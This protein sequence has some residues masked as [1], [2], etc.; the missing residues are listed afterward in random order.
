MGG[1]RE[2]FEE[3]HLV[4]GYFEIGLNEVT[5]VR[6]KDVFTILIFMLPRYLFPSISRRKECRQNLKII[7]I[8]P[9]KTENLTLYMNN[10]FINFLLT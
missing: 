7:F 1:R 4:L 10:E 6:V 8:S 5:F 9:S 3:V 2:I